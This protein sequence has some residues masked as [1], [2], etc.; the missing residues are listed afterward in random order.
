M[1]N[2]SHQFP[3]SERH[4][5]KEKEKFSGRQLHKDWRVWVALLLM[6]AAIIAYVLSLDD[7]IIPR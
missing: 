3:G 1:A 4:H 7:T 6:L 2:Q 5:H